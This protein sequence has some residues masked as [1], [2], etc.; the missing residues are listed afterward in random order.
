MLMVAEPPAAP[1]RSASTWK[2]SAPILITAICWPEALVV[3]LATWPMSA[4]VLSLTDSPAVTGA[5]VEPLW[6]MLG[7][8]LE[9]V[10]ALGGLGA[11]AVLLEG[12]AV[13]GAAAGAVVVAVSWAKAE[14]AERAMPMAASVAMRMGV[15]LDL[16]PRQVQNPRATPVVPPEWAAQIVPSVFSRALG[17]ISFWLS[18]TVWPRKRSTMERM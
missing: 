17:W 4:P 18:T 7:A 12:G 14:P 3:T 13:S 1:S 5:R 8:V 2:V 9:L 11:G 15:L 16:A 10:A 6:S